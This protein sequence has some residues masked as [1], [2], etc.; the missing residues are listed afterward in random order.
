MEVENEERS[1]GA[2]CHCLVQASCNF[3]NSC[4]C[5]F[6]GFT[7]INFMEVKKINQTAQVGARLIAFLLFFKHQCF[8]FSFHFET[9]AYIFLIKTAF[10]AQNRC[11]CTTAHGLQYSNYS[12]T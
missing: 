4:Q 7:N 2:E 9:F 5:I 12:T 8:T 6:T 1:S 11:F 10:P 3:G